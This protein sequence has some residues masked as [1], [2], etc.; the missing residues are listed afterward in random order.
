ML[1]LFSAVLPASHASPSFA[2][3][4]WTPG[5]TPA[6]CADATS[7]KGKV[8]N[9]VPQ[10]PCLLQGKVLGRVGG[11]HPVFPS[12]PWGGSLVWSREEGVHTDKALLSSPLPVGLCNHQPA[13]PSA[14][15]HP[16]QPESKVLPQ[17]TITFIFSLGPNP[18]PWGGSLVSRYQANK[19]YLPLPPAAVYV[20]SHWT[21]W[22]VGSGWQESQGDNRVGCNELS[23]GVHS[24]YS[25]DFQIN[26]HLIRKSS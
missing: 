16:A 14:P 20:A 11:L 18:C 23:S 7:R 15:L 3:R 13:W 6:P 24:T 26:T 22:R 25:S 12:P 1:T 10:N 17:V 21:A 8:G 9:Q 19:I 5:L 4:P 2:S